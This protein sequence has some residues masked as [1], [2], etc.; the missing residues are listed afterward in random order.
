MTDSQI[1]L[2]LAQEEAERL[3]SGKSSTVHDEV[4]PSMLIWQGLEIEDLQCVETLS[5]Y[6]EAH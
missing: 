3:A 4:T 6:I 2:R 1:R 5:F